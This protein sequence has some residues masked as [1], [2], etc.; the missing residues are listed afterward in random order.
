MEDQK[1]DCKKDHRMMNYISLNTVLVKELQ[2]HEQDYDINKI[3]KYFNYHRVTN[4]R[5]LGLMT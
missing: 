2:G 4:G 5:E 1:I 3:R